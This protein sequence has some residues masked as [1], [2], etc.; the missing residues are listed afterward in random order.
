MPTYNVENVK[1]TNKWRDLRLANKPRILPWKREKMPQVETQE[2]YSTLINTSST[3]ARRNEKIK[4]WRGLTTKSILYGSVM[5]NKLLQ[6]VRNIRRS[7]KL[8]HENL[9]SEIDSR[10]EKLNWSKDPE[11]YI[12]GRSTITIIIC[13]SDD[14]THSHSQ[15]MHR[16]IQI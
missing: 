3:K 11:R 5:D 1:C 8:Y 6:N 2:S 10:R 14:I 9:E 16:R 12:P 4:L 15:E 7:H 13:N